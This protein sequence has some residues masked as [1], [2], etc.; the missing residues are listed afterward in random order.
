[1][2]VTV[3]PLTDVDLELKSVGLDSVGAIR[4]TR[5]SPNQV[6]ESTLRGLIDDAPVADDEEFF[7]EVV[8]QP[9]FSGDKPERARFTLGASP[10]LNG[11]KFQWEVDVI[12]QENARGRDGEDQTFEPSGARTKKRLEVL[13]R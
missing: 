10:Y 7:F 6:T 11:S 2:P 5:I 1:M 13:R 8:R 12:S 4:L 3:S 9:R